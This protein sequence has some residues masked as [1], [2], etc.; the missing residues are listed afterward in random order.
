MVIDIFRAGITHHFFGTRCSR[1]SCGFYFPRF[2]ISVPAAI[3][4]TA[5]HIKIDF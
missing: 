4:F 3:E 2:Y 5:F 1:N